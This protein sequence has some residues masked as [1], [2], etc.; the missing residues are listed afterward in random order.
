A[1]AGLSPVAVLA[2]RA[3]GRHPGGPADRPAGRPDGDP[4]PAAGQARRGITI[5]RAGPSDLEAVVRL[6]LE[7]IRFDA[8]FGSGGERPGTVNA[9]RKEVMRLLDAPQP[10]I[11]LAERDR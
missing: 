1:H 7:V 3:R 9:L 6:G 4:D 10:W 5:R 8:Y 2:A 11:W